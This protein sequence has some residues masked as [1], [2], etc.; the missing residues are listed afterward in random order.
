MIDTL[1]GPHECRCG[2]TYSLVPGEVFVSDGGAELFAHGLC[3]CGECHVSVSKETP[4]R[5]AKWIWEQ[6]EAMWGANS[7]TTRWR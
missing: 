6:S 7:S 5:V 3:G 1:K 2:R 4:Y